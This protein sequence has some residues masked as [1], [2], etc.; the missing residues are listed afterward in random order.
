MDL[1]PSC[2]IKKIFEYN[3][4][5]NYKELQVVNIIFAYNIK[6]QLQERVTIRFSVYL[7]LDKDEQKY[8]KNIRYDIDDKLNTI[9]LPSHIKQLSFKTEF[10]Q[11]LE[12]YM[13]PDGLESLYFGMDFKN[14]DTAILPMVFPDSITDLYLGRSYTC[15]INVGVLPK[16]LKILTFGKYWDN[17]ILPNVLPNSLEELYFGKLFYGPLDPSVLPDNLK[18]LRVTRFYMGDLSIFPKQ[19]ECIREYD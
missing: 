10:N 12:K 11:K 15:P 2:I 17:E 13:I 6:R 9:M 14:E 16:K 7:L 18:Y 8:Y 5:E 1:L 3:G 4:I 19:I